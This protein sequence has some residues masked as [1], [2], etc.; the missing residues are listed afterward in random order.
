MGP[1][2]V[3]SV[4]IG[5]TVEP[6]EPEFRLEVDGDEEGEDTKRLEKKN[7][8]LKKALDEARL[9]DEDDEEN[10]QLSIEEFHQLLATKSPTEQLKLK[11]SRRRWQNKDAA[12]KCRKRK[13]DKIDK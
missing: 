9:V 3:R 2:T 12:K 4:T 11:E 6:S 1:R 7:K 10:G 8:A 5:K 13:L